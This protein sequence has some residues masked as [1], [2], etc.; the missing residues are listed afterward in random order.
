MKLYKKTKFS[1]ARNVMFHASC[2][3]DY[4]NKKYYDYYIVVNFEGPLPKSETLALTNSFYAP[5]LTKE[6]KQSS[7]TEYLEKIRPSFMWWKFVKY[8]HYFK[9]YDLLNA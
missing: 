7:P 3:T 5:I 4:D 2:C 8:L 1:I 6:Q 9:A